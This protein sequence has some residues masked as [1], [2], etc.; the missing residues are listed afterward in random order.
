MILTASAGSAEQRSDTRPD[1]VI[2]MLDTVRR[3]RLSTYGY[4][5]DTSPSLDAFSE[6]AMR[7]TN[8]YSTSCWTSP[9]HAS[10]FTGLYSAAHGTT[11]ENWSLSASFLTVAEMLKAGGYETAAVIGNPII[12]R[13]RG[14]AQGFDK[15]HESWR[16]TKRGKLEPDEVAVNWVSDFLDKRDSTRPL[17]LFI[18]LIGAHGPFDSCGKSCGAFGAKLAGGTEN[19]FWLDYYKGKRR[20]NSAHLARLSNLYDAEVLEVDRNFGHIMSSLDEVN[21]GAFIAV[22]SDHGENF[23]EHGHLNH[24]FSLHET[25][26]QIPLVVRYSPL[27][28]IPGIDAEPTQLVDL[29]PTI[30]RISRI[31]EVD[32]NS[33]QGM[34]LSGRRAGRPILT[35]YY[36]PRQALGKTMKSERPEIQAR[37]AQYQRRIKAIT[38][39]GWKLHWGDDGRFE[40]YH[41]AQDPGENT[42]L[43]DVEEHRGRS[44]ALEKMLTDLIDEY[45]RERSSA[46]PSPKIDAETRRELEALGYVE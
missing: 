37:L 33:V 6:R 27:F 10:L 14:F 15:F 32:S 16:H 1:I 38:A 3:D 22:T 30:S 17:F 5:R 29:F 39:D 31:A 35:E 26:T 28:P 20:L 12:S 40:L 13:D 44:A 8:A 42:D 43:A 41:L 2:I 34:D 21:S 19:S 23:G 18:N 24:V 4:E 36:R 45:H 25:T 7:F 46:E 11:Q 9:A